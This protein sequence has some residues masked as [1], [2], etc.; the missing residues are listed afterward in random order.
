MSSGEVVVGVTGGIAA[1]KTAA[2]VSQLVQ[3]GVSVTVVM[4]A[5][6]ERFVGKATF[7]ALTGRPVATEVFDDSQFPLGAHITLA[8]QAQLLCVAPATASFLA[9]CAHGLADDLLSTLY[10]SFRGSVLMAPAMNAEMWDK[11]VVQRNVE[12]L[13]ADGVRMIDPEEGWLSCREQGVG[14]MAS[15]ERIVQEIQQQLPKR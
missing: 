8:R 13:V 6:A 12:Q 3:S 5:S 10:L 14:R 4:T 1:Y 11:A 2:V 7:A 9:R 15:P